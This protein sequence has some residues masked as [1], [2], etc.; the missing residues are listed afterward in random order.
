MPWNSRKS[1]GHGVRF[2]FEYA[3]TA[4]IESSSRSSNRATDM[5]CWIIAAA[6][7][8][9]VFKTLQ[10]AADQGKEKPLWNQIH[11]P[12]QR[13]FLDKDAIGSEPQL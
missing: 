9:A 8:T 4:D 5:P 3:L 13:C 11:K 6:E 12:P 2:I 1:V 10:N 7:S